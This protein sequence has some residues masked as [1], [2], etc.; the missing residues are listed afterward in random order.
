METSEAKKSKKSTS[1]KEVIE[2]A[3][4]AGV[5]I[6]DYKFMD[7]P[8]TLQHIS[9]HIDTLK[10][11]VFENGIGFDGSSIRG[12][13]AINESDML[14][15]PDPETAIVDPCCKTPTLSMFCNIE[16]PIERKPYSRDSRYVAQKAEKFLIKSGI[17]T[18]CFF[19]PE[20]EFFVFD[21]IR[22]DQNQHS[23]YYYIDSAE[24]AW[25][26]GRDEKPNLGYKPRYKEGYFPCPPTDSLMEFR[27]QALLRMREMGLD[28]EIHHHEVATAGQ[29]EMGV[30]IKTLT[31][32]ADQ[33]TLY[34]YVLKNVAREH[35]K[36]V[37]FMPKP[38][39]QD[40]G[41]G[42]HCHQSIWKDGVPLMF[43]KKMTYA[44]FSQIGLW[45][46]GGLLKHAP[47]LLAIT[48]PTT[49]SYRRLVPGFEA[50]VNLCYSARNRSAVCR[51]PTYSNEP[52]AKR[53]EFRAPDATC[54]PYLAFA[55]MLMA[56]LDGI[57]NKIDPGEPA[58]FDLFEA[59]PEELAKIKTVP[60]SLG[61]ALTALEKDH[62][63]LL[64]GDVFTK[65]LIET[66]IEYKKKKE[67]DF[68]RLRPHPAEFQLYFDA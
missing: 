13:Q 4:E 53:V 61:G 40:N 46:I 44:N 38:I 16:D 15:M 6:V 57:I 49:N 58:D 31:K 33:I 7:L 25:N 24:G 52:K 59:S 64:R 41:N 39:F 12:F 11:S 67:I 27:S 65:D 35:F 47:A 48:S 20:A 23:A 37:T 17:A 28:M 3:K 42:M 55:A 29:C 66:Y 10:E 21:G 60:D 8:G 43:D 1:P 63:F 32:A 68:V 30:G 9:Y 56:G 54:N 19:G 2:M 14:L 62:D 22:F 5:Q 26:S 36:V 50:P 51:I 18:Q 34:K 45:Y